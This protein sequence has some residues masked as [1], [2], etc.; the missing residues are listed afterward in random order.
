MPFLVAWQRGMTSNPTV[1]NLSGL[2]LCDWDWPYRFIQLCW[3]PWVGDLS[4]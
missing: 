1:K 2:R 3:V 4:L